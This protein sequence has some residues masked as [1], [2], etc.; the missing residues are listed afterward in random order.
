MLEIGLQ[1]ARREQTI[2]VFCHMRL[3]TA[4]NKE[5][6]EHVCLHR[7]HSTKFRL[8]PKSMFWNHEGD[9]ND[10]GL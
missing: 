3:S 2:D 10:A 5:I 9:G 4:N 1:S 8:H 6:A 7:E